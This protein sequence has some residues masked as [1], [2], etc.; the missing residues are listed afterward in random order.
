MADTP[1][2][3]GYEN[4]EIVGSGGFGTVYRARQSYTDQRVAIKVLGG[5]N[6]NDTKQ[7]DR[8][9]REGRAMSEVGNIPHIV[10]VFEAKLTEDGRPCLVMPFFEGGSLG[11]RLAANG[12]LSVEQSVVVGKVIAEA[13]GKVHRRGITHRD[14][15]P[16]NILVNEDGDVALTDFGLAVAEATKLGSESGLMM[17]PAHASPERLQS[18][19]GRVDDPVRSDIYSLGST[20]YTLMAGQPPFGTAA[21]TGPFPLMDR[22]VNEP[23]PPI[24]ATPVPH[25]LTLVLERAMAKDPQERFASA[26]ELSDAL[27]RVPTTVERPIDRP[28][29]PLGPDG[30]AGV[31][32]ATVARDSGGAGPR[33]EAGSPTIEQPSGSGSPTPA[34]AS[35]PTEVRQPQPGSPTSVD[36]APDVNGASSRGRTMGFVIGGAAILVVLLVAAAVVVT[37]ASQPKTPGTPGGPSDTAPIGTVLT[38][39]APP[40]VDEVRLLSTGGLSFTWSYAPGTEGQPVVG[41]EVFVDGKRSS[42]GSVQ[43]EATGNPVHEEVLS[44]KALGS[45]GTID[46][47]VHKYCVQTFL[48]LTTGTSDRNPPVCLA[49]P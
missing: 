15:K 39:S 34:G 38:G 29:L 22:V 41:Y 18:V 21:D 36:S 31:S 7:R 6:S 2:V 27:S 13:L 30:S 14:I 40:V 26:S 20:I 49:N 28:V 45:I 9:L 33:N 48:V 43:P 16:E 1:E 12:P 46:P 3:S 8:F 4:L 17:T 44:E 25:A 37:R 19:D 47:S 23:L 11:D 10:P 24:T 32:G 5:I 35:G 42:I